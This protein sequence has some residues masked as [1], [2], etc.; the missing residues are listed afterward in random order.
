M[1][2]QCVYWNSHKWFLF[3]MNIDIISTGSKI[4]SYGKSVDYMTF[5]AIHCT[6]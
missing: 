3:V 4:F 2:I 5:K 6:Q 1:E